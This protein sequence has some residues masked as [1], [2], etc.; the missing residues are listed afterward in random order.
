MAK[1]AGTLTANEIYTA[2]YNMIISQRVYDITT[3]DPSLA[4]ALRVD[5]TLYG[6]TKLRS[7]EHTS[8]LQSHA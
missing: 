4:N 3:A 1:F 2:L 7:E 6:D 5:G 8:E